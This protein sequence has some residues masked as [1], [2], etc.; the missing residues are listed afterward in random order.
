MNGNSPNTPGP[1]T[2]VSIPTA[3]DLLPFKGVRQLRSVGRNASIHGISLHPAFRGFVAA[4]ISQRDAKRTNWNRGEWKLL[5]TAQTAKFP[6]QFSHPC[7]SCQTS[8]LLLISTTL[9]CQTAGTLFFSASLCGRGTIRLLRMST[10]VSLGPRI[11][12]PQPPFFPANIQ[13]QRLAVSAKTTIVQRLDGDGIVLAIYQKVPSERR[14]M[15][16]AAAR[17]EAPVLRYT[18]PLIVRTLL[19]VVGEATSST[20]WGA[21]PCRSIA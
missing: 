2:T 6:L 21:L 14:I 3:S 13:P 1:T 8:C 10:K 12:E 18:E 20:K 11:E 15:V 7:L 5:L 9:C 17:V 4:H 19:R 16:L